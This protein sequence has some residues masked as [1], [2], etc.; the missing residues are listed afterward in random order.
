MANTDADTEV[1]PTWLV[2]QLTFAR[3]GVRAVAG[4]VELRSVPASLRP[5]SAC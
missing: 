5:R 2:D 4:T 3:A 1:P